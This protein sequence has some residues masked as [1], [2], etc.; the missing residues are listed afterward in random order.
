MNN[1]VALFLAAFSWCQ[2]LALS[3]AVIVVYYV[4]IAL[5][6]RMRL[7]AVQITLCTL[8]IRSLLPGQLR[9]IVVGRYDTIAFAADLAEMAARGMIT[10]VTADGWWRSRCTLTIFDRA[11]YALPEAYRYALAA[12]D[13]PSTFNLSTRER[14]KMRRLRRRLHNY[15]AEISP[16]T[17]NSFVWHVWWGLIGPLLALF[18]MFFLVSLYGFGFECAV[19]LLVY[20]IFCLLGMCALRTYT[21]SGQ[22]L[23]TH[24][25]EFKKQV[26]AHPCTD[27][28]PY[29]LALSISFR[30]ALCYHTSC[31]FAHVCAPVAQLDR[32][33]DS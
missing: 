29:A 19:G 25:K 24:I 28:V 9:Y 17:R 14:A 23:A 33:T 16:D 12:L 20:T 15:C 3:V 7:H 31:F 6:L 1:E 27:D 11:S 10:I 22:V 2:L 32:A 8:S 21:P 4:A 18:G 30:P 26:C 5:L 13:G